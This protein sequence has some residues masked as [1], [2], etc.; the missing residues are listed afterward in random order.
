MVAILHCWRR[1]DIFILCCKLILGIHTKKTGCWWTQ[2]R[3]ELVPTCTN[4]E[5]I[6]LN[7]NIYMATYSIIKPERWRCF[8]SNWKWKTFTGRT[9]GRW[10]NKNKQT[11]KPGTQ[12]A[13]STLLFKVH[14]SSDQVISKGFCG[15][16][17][18]EQT[19]WLQNS[20]SR[21]LGVLVL[22]LCISGH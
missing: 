17:L 10:K 15:G 13:A 18:G 11:K 9:S 4:D 21:D 16:C 2:K 8:I 6:S 14:M 3:T 12:K 22:P 5:D 19:P 7:C 20:G 1:L